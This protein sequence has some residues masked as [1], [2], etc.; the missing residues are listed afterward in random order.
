MHSA[1][2]AAAE[3]ENKGERSK[4]HT[5]LHVAWNVKSKQY[6][7]RE[8]EREREKTDTEEVSLTK[9]GEKFFNKRRK[10]RCQKQS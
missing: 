3:E 4:L 9:Y 6:S 2:G 8:R 7:E 1:T 10:K 5:S